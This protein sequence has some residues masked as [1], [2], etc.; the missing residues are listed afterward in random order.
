MTIPVVWK[1]YRVETPSRGYWDQAMLERL[2]A[3]KIWGIP[4]GYTFK[5]VTTFEEARADGI[6]LVIPGQHHVDFVHEINRDI[7]RYKWILIVIAGDEDSIFPVKELA[8]PNMMVWVMTPRPGYDYSDLMVRFIGEGAAPDAY[9]MIPEMHEEYAKKQKKG[10]FSGQNTHIRREECIKGLESVD[11]FDVY[12]TAG[13]TQGMGHKEYY[14]NMAS[15][16]IVPCPS[17]ACTQDSFRLYEALEAGCVPLA[18]A[19]SPKEGGNPGYWDMV[20]G[21]FPIP[22]VEDWSKVKDLIELIESDYAAVQHQ[23]FSWWQQA[24]RGMV[25]GLAED[26]QFLSEGKSHSPL[27]V[28]KFHDITVLVSSSS[29]PSHPSTAMLEKTLESIRERLPDA[30]IIIM[31]DGL[32][33]R[34]D[35]RKADYDAYKSEVLWKCNHEW[36]NV[37][38]IVFDGYIH[39]AKMTY[40]ALHQVFSP[41]ILFVEHDTPLIGEIDFDMLSKPLLQGSLDVL[42]LLH[43]AAP[44]PDHKHLLL[45]NGKAQDIDGVP[46]IRTTQWS[47]RP[48]LA[49]TSYYRDMLVENFE[50]DYRYFIEDKMHSVVQNNDWKENKIA[51]YAPEGNMK[52][53]DNLDGRGEDP[54]FDMP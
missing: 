16:R 17:G 29:I 54:K 19:L 33:P 37:L 53:S 41:L 35:H 42:R 43:E 8:H 32:D 15:A 48:H 5:S 51:I 10:F 49:T 39:Q 22:I 44:L 9:T 6:V 7:A 27:N 52:R 50:E 46:A 4:G 31:L 36:H 1:S 34:L 21:S 28:P 3:G 23:I 24:K 45:D 40:R 13:F 11:G 2:F 47:Q 18:D 12:P 26:I 30:E 38:P 14:R 25:Y 20:F